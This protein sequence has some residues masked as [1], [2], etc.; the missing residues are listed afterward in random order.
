MTH[1]NS[2]FVKLVIDTAYAN[3]YMHSHDLDIVY[4]YSKLVKLV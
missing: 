3:K 1:L 2:K 4:L